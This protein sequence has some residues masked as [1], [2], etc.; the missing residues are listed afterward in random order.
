MSAS[1]DTYGFALSTGNKVAAEAYDTGARSYVAWRADAVG[2]LDAAIVADPDF[3]M[4]RLVK[5][6]I[7][8]SAR[9]AR[10]NPAVDALLAAAKPHLDDATARERAVAEALRIAHGGNLQAGVSKLE[11]WVAEHPTDIVAHRMLQFELFWSGESTWM[12]DVVERAARAWNEDI[13]DFAQ[14]QA[15]RAFSNEEGGDY[16]TAERVGRD[17]VAREPES[18]WGAHAVA[19]VL[20]MQGR[21][22]DGVAWLEGL[23]GNWGRANQLAHHN[24]WHLCLFL[25]EQGKHERILELLDTK[26]RNPDSPLVQA[27]PDAP[28][29][30]QNVA[31]LLMRL[32]LRGVD[33]GERWQTIADI[34]AGRTTDHDNP[35]A[36]AHDAMVLAA[37]G[38]FEK[39]EELLAD[40]RGT[41]VAGVIGNTTR[42]VAVPLVEAMAAHR[43][44]EYDRVVDLMWPIRRNL[45]QVGGSHAQRDI[46]Y[47][48]LIDAAMRARRK[49][50]LAVLLDDVRS[51]GFKRVAERTLYRDAFAAMA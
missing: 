5:G 38:R 29:D 2:H 30:L 21:V 44:K 35:F 19:H 1:T 48:M 51:I 47:Q 24:W 39:V 16:E 17:A 40:M 7:L 12:R 36:S 6:W 18:P 42:T 34:C 4:P 23:C 13:P 33:V 32:E 31:S 49:A 15:V 27:M 22:D 45:P 46:F 11:A 14:F 41:D 25:L 26:V 9:A 10:F 28:M 3:P 8:H 20:V 50:Q 43:R 37:V